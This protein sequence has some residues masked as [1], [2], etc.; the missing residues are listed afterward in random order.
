MMKIEN[1]PATHESKGGVDRK[2]RSNPLAAKPRMAKLTTMNAK[3]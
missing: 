3:W 2:V 1:P